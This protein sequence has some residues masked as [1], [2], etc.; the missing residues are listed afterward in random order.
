ML[1]LLA[2]PSSWAGSWHL[3]Q[4]RCSSHPGEPALGAK[5]AQ[6]HSRLAR[7]CLV[8]LPSARGA[9]PLSSSWVL[10][11]LGCVLSCTTA[12]HNFAFSCHLLSSLSLCI[13]SICFSCS[14][15]NDVLLVTLNI[16]NPL[17]EAVAAAFKSLKISSTMTHMLNCQLIV[18][19]LVTWISLLRCMCPCISL[20][21]AYS[22]SLFEKLKGIR[23]AQ[24]PFFGKQKFP[25]LCLEG[26]VLP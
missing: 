23:L 21:W 8:V 4:H 14:G 2:H 20:K 24:N 1:R 5:P 15:V 19:T 6:K 10:C 11:Q 17:P 26:D 18:P 25:K 22:L 3:C 16:R 7:V 9:H 13:Y 12:L